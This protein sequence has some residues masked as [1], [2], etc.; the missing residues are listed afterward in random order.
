MGLACGL[1]HLMR[2]AQPA[3]AAPRIQARSRAAVPDVLCVR[4]RVRILLVH[5][6]WALALHA[7]PVGQIDTR[8]RAQLRAN[9]RSHTHTR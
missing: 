6:A 1:E 2:R 9:A 8:A 7:A 3:C 4:M 5:F